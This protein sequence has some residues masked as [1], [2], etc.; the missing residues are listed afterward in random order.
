MANKK[1]FRA[2]LSKRRRT[3]RKRKNASRRRV[4]KP[5]KYMF[6]NGD[7]L[8]SVKLQTGAIL[9]NINDNKPIKSDPNTNYYLNT[10]VGIKKD[11]ENGKLVGETRQISDE[12]KNKYRVNNADII[13]NNINMQNNN[14]VDAYIVDAY[15]DDA[16]LYPSI[17]SENIGEPVGKVDYSNE[18]FNG[19][20]IRR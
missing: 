3:G 19:T 14:I 2:K 6:G 20:G 5:R 10:S 7:E 18:L 11:F 9:T 1:T 13:Y 17:Y 15:I 12:K 8:E 16:K 4:N